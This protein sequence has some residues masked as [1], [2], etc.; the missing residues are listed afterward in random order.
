L[1]QS[2]LFFI[3]KA[4]THTGLQWIC[5]L[6]K[7]KHSLL[8]TQCVF[9]Q[10]WFVKGSSVPYTRNRPFALLSHPSMTLGLSLGLVSCVHV[11]F[12]VWIATIPCRSAPFPLGVQDAH[13]YSTVVWL[14]ALPTLYHAVVALAMLESSKSGQYYQLCIPLIECPRVPALVSTAQGILVFVLW[15]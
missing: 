13:F 8:S 15:Q 14:F 9:F 6:H 1:Q 3:F 2:L 10:L 7:A 4:V 5:S 11:P 12:A